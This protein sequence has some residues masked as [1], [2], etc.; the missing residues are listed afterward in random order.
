MLPSVFNLLVTRNSKSGMKSCSRLRQW[1]QQC[2]DTA[3]FQTR[4]TSYAEMARGYLRP[5]AACIPRLNL[6]GLIVEEQDASLELAI[7]R[8]MSAQN[9]R[10][11]DKNSCTKNYTIWISQ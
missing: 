4:T 1:R 5:A 7:L 6:R 11:C 3:R 8:A 9:P 10:I 2:T